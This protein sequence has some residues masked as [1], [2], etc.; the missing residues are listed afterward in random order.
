MMPGNLECRLGVTGVSTIHCTSPPCVGEHTRLHALRTPSLNH[1]PGV[2]PG[3][4]P[5]LL[6]PYLSLL[7]IYPPPPFSSPSPLLPIS[8]SSLIPFP[9]MSPPLPSFSSFFLSPPPGSKEGSDLHQFSTS[10]TPPP[11]A[12]PIRPCHRHQC[13]DQ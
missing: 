3:S 9:P 7:L 2:E 8:L 10:T 4:E 11:D 5:S 1:I 6:L 13:Q 12:V